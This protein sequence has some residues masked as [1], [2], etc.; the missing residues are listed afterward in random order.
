[1]EP[2]PVPGDPAVHV[3][4]AE[5]PP[6][7]LRSPYAAILYVFVHHLLDARPPEVPLPEGL[8]DRARA[9]GRLTS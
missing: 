1:M 2:N 7:R 5:L 6:M 9:E 8:L 4:A 3:R